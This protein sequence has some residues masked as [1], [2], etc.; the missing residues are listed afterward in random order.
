MPG[1][2]TVAGVLAHMGYWDA[3]AIYWLDKWSRTGEPTP[4]EPENVEAVND[5]AKP[6]CLALRPRDAAQLALPVGSA[7]W[8]IWAS[9]SHLAGM[10][11]MWLCYVFKEPGGKTTAFGDLDLMERGWEDDPE[12]PRGADELVDALES[13]WRIVA[14]ALD[15]WTLDS[16]AREERRVRGTEVQFH[17][18]QSVLYRMLTHDA[19]HISEI[20]L[21][22]GS[23]GLGEIDIWR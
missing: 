1:G 22:L 2:W 5:A 20:S 18:R 21:T 3:R 23:H 16:L 13:S 17:T 19:Y 9:A 11:V 15:T 8:P 10:R 6:L 12:H 4:Y 7:T 14:R